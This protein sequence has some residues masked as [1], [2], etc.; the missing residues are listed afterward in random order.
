MAGKGRVI[1]SMRAVQ[2]IARVEQAV[3]RENN[4]APCPEGQGAPIRY[5]EIV[6]FRL[7]PVNAA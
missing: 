1:A 3:Y 6:A 5:G 4:G 7:T 2:R